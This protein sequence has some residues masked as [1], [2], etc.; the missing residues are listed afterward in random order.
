[1]AFTHITDEDRANKGVTGLSDTPGLTT[2]ALQEKFDEL[3][4]MGIDGLNKVLDELE[5]QYGASNIGATVP[6][7]LKANANIQ[8]IINALAFTLNSVNNKAHQ[9]ANKTVLDAISESVK[10]GYDKLA[11][12]FNNAES[13][14]QNVTDSATSVPSAAAIRSYVR[15]SDVKQVIVNIV[16]PIGS[17]YVSSSN[18]EPTSLFGGTWSV[19]DLGIASIFAWR[20]TA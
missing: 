14:D 17:V 11:S 13:F 3:G 9:H 18:I 6:S 8:G 5:G 2:A 1:M 7:T 20:R 16:Y 10:A 12:V 15:S 4:N 19:V